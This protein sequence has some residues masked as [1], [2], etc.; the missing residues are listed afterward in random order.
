MRGTVVVTGAST[1]IGEAAARHLA[2][3]GFDVLAGVRS[4]E[5]AERA[6]TTGLE[7]LRIDV[8]DEDSVAA[9]A[10]FVEDRVGDR[11][12][13]GRVNNAGVAVTGRSSSRRSRSGAASSR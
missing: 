4:D 9:A 1:G 8:T 12:L 2:D 13:D 10:A 5:A 11:G 7:P 3:R 6:R